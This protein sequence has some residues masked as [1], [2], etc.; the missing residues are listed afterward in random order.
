MPALSD[1]QD[2]SKFNL[3]VVVLA[4][5]LNRMSTYDALADRFRELVEAATEKGVVTWLARSDSRLHP[6]LG[7][8]SRR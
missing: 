4:A 1:Q 3:A 8:A 7:S 6:T 5:G 2:L